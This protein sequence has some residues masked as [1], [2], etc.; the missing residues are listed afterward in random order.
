MEQE[1]DPYY[2]FGL[3][4]EETSLPAAVNNI[5]YNTKE[6][7]RNEFTG[8][9]L[10]NLEWEDYGARMQD[11]QI[12]RWNQLDPLAEKSRR[13][14]PY[15]YG[16][17]NPVRF[18]DPDG[19][20]TALFDGET[21]NEDGSET[22]TG[23]AAKDAF[24][25]LQAGMGAEENSQAQAATERGNGP[26]ADPEPDAGGG[27]KDKQAAKNSPNKDMH[28]SEAGY[29]FLKAYE[30]FRPEMYNLNDGGY[31]IGYGY[32]IPIGD[33]SKF[34]N[35]I[36]ESGADVLLHSIM[37]KYENQVRNYIDV[38]LTQNQ[39]DALVSLAYNLRGGLSNASKLVDAINNQVGEEKMRNTWY[40]YSM[41]N[42]PDLHTGLLNRRKDEFEI[43][44]N[45]NY[46]RDY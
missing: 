18:I 29:G 8:T 40:L 12:G 44:Q 42:R 10:Q 43:W 27:N 31:T 30:G 14:S 33:E 6:L 37:D 25:D 46:T 7:Q 11:P 32:H 39:F 35:G 13:W 17:D 4:L 28:L 9:G 36:T 5:K 41:P 16:V 20:N 1:E 22:L 21:Q 24:R 19:M 3:N 26:D 2:P 45:I 38:A 23:Q 15:V 34:A